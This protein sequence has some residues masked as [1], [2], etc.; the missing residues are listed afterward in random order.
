[1]SLSFVLIT[2]MAGYGYIS[3]ADISS[4]KKRD[5]L[6]STLS[7][8]RL[9]SELIENDVASLKSKTLFFIN[10]LLEKD[11]KVRGFENELG[12]KHLVI[13]EINNGK[14]E[15]A[16]FWQAP[17]EKSKL[18]LPGELMKTLTLKAL[19]QEA[20][21][22]YQPDEQEWVVSFRNNVENSSFVVLVVADK[23]DLFKNF[24]ESGFGTSYI[25]GNEKQIV[26][27]SDIDSS[28]NA[29]TELAN[30]IEAGRIN[31]VFQSG[32]KDFLRYVSLIPVKNLG[33]VASVVS[34]NHIQAALTSFFVTS[35]LFFLLVLCLV[36][37]I[38]ILLSHFLTKRLSNLATMAKEVAQGKFD[39]QVKDSSRDEIGELGQSFN[40]MSSKILELIEET[41][42]KARM[43]GEL[44]VAQNVQ[45]SL[46]PNESLINQDV[47]VVG[48]YKPASECGG[49]LWSYKKVGDRLIV[50]IGDATGHG[51]A[52]ALVTSAANSVLSLIP[53]QPNLSVA[54]IIKMINRVIYETS[55]GAINMTFFLASIDL[56]TY[57]MEYCLASH[58]P[59][60]KTNDGTDVDFYQ[61][62]VGRRLGEAPEYDAII[63]NSTLQKGDKILLYTDGITECKNHKGRDFGF[64]KLS[65]L[66]LKS[67]AEGHDLVSQCDEIKDTVYAYKGDMPQE[68]DIT[69]CLI[70]VG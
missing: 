12:I 22:K 48:H 47:K 45:S 27:S 63:G 67:V 56:K 40:H 57:E 59:P 31:G 1:M 18:N 53:M 23:G 37:I 13:S 68:D 6:N 20:A 50:C 38:S 52:P 16:F 55:K 8:T 10:K 15:P 26:V 58:D 36:P 43:E 2:A 11:E 46:V 9:L 69:Y 25:I 32:K 29:A 42:E 35:I 39:I 7:H 19:S 5:L 51:V 66:W 65:K 24:W 64:K 41:K 34:E 44:K 17:S 70:E 14:I 61:D 21:I 3:G 4:Q 49:D 62:L 30:A 60:I 33:W 28:F 54:E